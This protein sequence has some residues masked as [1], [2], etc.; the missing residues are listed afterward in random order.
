VWNI[1]EYVPMWKFIED[2]GFTEEHV[3][4]YFC[5]N[6]LAILFAIKTGANYDKSRLQL[7]FQITSA[8]KKHYRQTYQIDPFIM[9]R[10]ARWETR[11]VAVQDNYSRFSPPSPVWSDYCFVPNSAVPIV[12]K[13]LGN[14]GVG[15]Y[16]NIFIDQLDPNRELPTPA[17]LSI[18][19]Q[20]LGIFRI[21]YP[22]DIHKNIKQI[23]PS[24]IEEATNPGMVLS[25]AALNTSI[26]LA[27][28]H[29][30]EA[31]ISVVWNLDRFDRFS[32]RS[33]NYNNLLSLVQKGADAEAGGLEA[34]TKVNDSKYK[35]ITLDYSRKGGEGPTLEY[36][37]KL[38]YAR[39]KFPEIAGEGQIQEKDAAN[40]GNLEAMAQSEGAKLINQYLDRV[41]GTATYAGAITGA[42]KLIGNISSIVYSFSSGRGLETRL[43]LA[44]STPTPEIQQTLDQ[45]TLSYLQRQVS[46]AE[47]KNLIAVGVSG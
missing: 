23:I 45:D 40:I 18:V 46:R 9:D 36:L 16:Y 19:N 43:T 33:E 2:V 12:A 35:T 8:I 30:M 15:K 5:S 29:T 13:K 47:E 1:G 39:Y 21:E 6:Q 44:E 42:L 41:S 3:R 37:S 32:S 31:I 27:E 24:A 26:K 38:D 11:R 22:R 34:S 7:A 10:I 14:W 4:S 28:N 20:S 25:T 17:N